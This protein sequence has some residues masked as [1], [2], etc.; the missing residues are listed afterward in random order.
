MDRYSI[1]IH[2][3]VDK[4]SKLDETRHEVIYLGERTDK[5]AE[6]F[7]ESILEGTLS[8]TD[9]DVAILVKEVKRT[10][11]IKQDEEGKR[12][13][14]K[15]EKVEFGINV[16]TM[17]LAYQNFLASNPLTEPIAEEMNLAEFLSHPRNNRKK[18]SFISE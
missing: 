8:A 2:K 4:K 18:G 1:I 9:F 10:K 6:G 15:R 3:K 7:L 13:M 5:A 14:R 17:D 12:V 11:I 16:D